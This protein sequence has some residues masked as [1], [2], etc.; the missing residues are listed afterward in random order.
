MKY[1]V[2]DDFRITV[3]DYVPN[4]QQIEYWG[5]MTFEGERREVRDIHR[6]QEGIQIELY[7]KNFI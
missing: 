3:L 6:T 1:T 4:I 7:P 5:F 2:A